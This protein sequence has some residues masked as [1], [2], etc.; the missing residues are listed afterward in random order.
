MVIQTKSVF[1]YVLQWKLIIVYFYF[2]E[3]ELGQYVNKLKNILPFL[4]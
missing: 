4:D 3:Y 1:K 2:D